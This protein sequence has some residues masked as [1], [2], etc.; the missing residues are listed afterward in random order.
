M[1]AI[2]H[3]GVLQ[4][5]AINVGRDGFEWDAIDHQVDR[6]VFIGGFGVVSPS[7]DA[8]VSWAVETANRSVFFGL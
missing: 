2:A 7:A 6:D 3:A 8:S 4:V 1:F 5:L